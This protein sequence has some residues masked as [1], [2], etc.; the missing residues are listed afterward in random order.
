MVFQSTCFQKPKA[1]LQCLL[2]LLVLL[3]M[4]VGLGC[5]P[6]NNTDKATD[7]K[8]ALSTQAVRVTGSDTMVHLSTQWA[9]ALMKEKPQIQVAINGGGSGNG[10][11]AL[12]RGATDISPSS[13]ELKPNELAQAKKQKVQLIQ[14]PV[15][16]DAIAIIVN[17]DNAIKALTL[18]QS[19]SI[20]T[21]KIENWQSI[22]HQQKPILVYSRESSSGTF[23]FFQ[24]HV[25]NKQDFTL[26]ARMIPSTTAIIEAVA[27]D[28]A[29]IGY[30]GLGY[31]L[32]AKDKVKILAIQA[33]DITGKPKLI[34]PTPETVYSRKY[35]ISRL[36]YLF[37]NHQKLGLASRQFLAFAQSPQGQKIVQDNGFLPLKRHSQGLRR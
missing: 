17:P 2:G 15:A 37:A 1:L 30:V 23:E 29:S 24:E 6:S 5:W 12:L 9:E 22:N 36:L 14:T 35:P 31:A 10:I 3:M 25:L 16:V 7:K 27:Q 11:A 34:W 21:G 26:K 8:T 18:E 19:Q 4:L 13:R 20:F 32:E 33:S 28:K